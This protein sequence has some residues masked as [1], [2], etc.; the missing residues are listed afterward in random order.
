MLPGMVPRILRPHALTAVLQRQQST[1]MAQ[2]T[3]ASDSHALDSTSRSHVAIARSTTSRAGHARP[4]VVTRI[5]AGGVVLPACLGA[6]RAAVGGDVKLHECSPLVRSGGGHD[7]H[8]DTPLER[9]AHVQDKNPTYM[10]ERRRQQRIN[11][12]AVRAVAVRA[13]RRWMRQRAAPADR[14]TDRQ[15]DSAQPNGDCRLRR[16]RRKDDGLAEQW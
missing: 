2:C 5:T 4:A 16:G 13:P 1:R 14:P 12:D 6:P 3:S 8:S 15:R 10:G 9:R 11:G 7:T